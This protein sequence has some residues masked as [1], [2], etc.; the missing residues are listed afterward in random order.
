MVAARLVAVLVAALTLSAPASADDEPSTSTA[1]T[2]LHGFLLRADESGVTTFSRTPSFAWEAVRG[3]LH[4]EFQLST[5]SVFREGALVYTNENVK[6]PVLALPLSLPWVTGNPYALYARVRAVLASGVTPWSNDFGFNMRWETTPA[7]LSSY[8]G[9]V[10][11]TPIEGA[12]GYDVWFP[13]AGKVISTRTNVADQR[14]FYSFHTDATWTSSVKWR[15]RASRMPYGSRK[16]TLPAASYGPWS[17]LY[18]S[19]NPSFATGTMTTL[20]GVSDVVSDAVGALDP[21]R[22]TPGFAFSGNTSMSGQ[23]DELYRVHVFT[24]RDCVNAVYRGAVVGSPAYAPRTSGPLQLPADTADLALA[25]GRFLPDG[26]E[27]KQKT[28]DGLE[29]ESAEAQDP[30]KPDT[31]AIEPPAEEGTGGEGG[32]G[33]EGSG[34][35]GTGGTG[36]ETPPSGTPPASGSPG[37]GGAPGTGSEQGVAELLPVDTEALGAPVDLWDTS[38]PSSG[39]YW[40]VVTVKPVPQTPF[41]TTLAVAAPAGSS[42]L[43]LLNVGTLAT[44][45]TIAIDLDPIKEERQILSIAGNT[46]TLTTPTSFAHQVGAKI[47]QTNGTFMYVDQE[48]PGDVCAAGRVEEFGKTSEPVVAADSTPY[49]SGLSVEGNL[50]SASSSAPTFYGSPVVAWAPALGAHAYELQW[51]KSSYP[52]KAEGNM[53][54][55]AT[56]ANV[57]LSPG[58]WFYRVRGLN[59]S[60]PGAGQKMT[61]SDPAQVSIAQPTF[62]VVKKAKSSTPSAKKSSV[63]LTKVTVKTAGFSIGMPKGWLKADVPKNSSLKFAAAVPT[64]ENGVYTNL[65]VVV[66]AGRGSKS[67]AAWTK[68][69]KAE[70]SSLAVAGSLTTSTVKLPAGTAIK[71]SYRV[72]AEDGRE[73]AILQYAIDRVSKSY[74][75]TFTTTPSLSKKYAP[76]FLASAKSFKLTG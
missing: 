27:R 71:L 31:P 32:S 60:L 19:V 47:V 35:G 11:W 59:L 70:V 12:T 18:S 57:T 53:Y 75:L 67:F 8:P 37:Q 20:A 4:Y 61:W 3:A 58:E 1:P 65:N 43:T 21:H 9:L 23:V 2:G 51:S 6:G 13:D 42:S 52:F 48:L 66:G 63:A 36:G 10:R 72:T 41:Q 33:S 69:V 45:D 46:V 25:R 74:I 44:D 15:V 50:S 28:V 5:S 17:P 73:A 55:F 62:M 54:T 49:V 14:E 24:D 38:W 64:A 26:D 29:F 76:V 30:A 56:S 16:N 39:Y 22:L 34:T 7:P 40:T 68:Q